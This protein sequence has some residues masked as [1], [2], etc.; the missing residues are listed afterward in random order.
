MSLADIRRIYDYADWASE[1]MLAAIAALTEEQQTRDIV[2]SFPN[3]RATLAHIVGAEWL[4]LQRLNGVSPGAPP[5]W[6][7]SGSVA[8]LAERAAAI[9]AERRAL[10]ERL[11]E[12][13]LD[14]EFAYK[15]LKGEAFNSRLRDV[16]LHISNHA[17]YH[18]GQLATMMRQ[19]GA[20]PPATDF[21]VFCRETSRA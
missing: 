21:I 15:N 7:A 4:W 14:Q 9:A 13:A 3:I 10:L 20:T 18:R 12:R 17:S 19:A 8:Q 16:L 6:V 11:D 2:S 1:R 5:E